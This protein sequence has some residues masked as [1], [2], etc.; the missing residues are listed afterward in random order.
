MKKLIS[1]KTELLF[2]ITFVVGL[3][4][5]ILTSF[6]IKTYKSNL[7]DNLKNKAKIFAKDLVASCSDSL[8]VNQYKTLHSLVER[9]IF[10]DD[11]I[12][13]EIYDKDSGEVIEAKITDA[14]IN[15]IIS[16]NKIDFNS[17][18][19][20]TAV[21]NKS[22]RNARVFEV[23][24]PIL[25]EGE[26]IFAI[27]ASND[28]I[29]SIKLKESI[30]AVRVTLSFANTD[31][32]IAK[33]LN[34]AVLISIVVVIFCLGLSLLLVRIILDPIE[35]L[36]ISVK[37][38]PNGK[39]SYKYPLLKIREIEYL[40]EA[41][42]SIEKHFDKNL[43]ALS[44]EKSEELIK[45]KNNLELV[46]KELLESERFLTIGSLAATLTHEIKNPLTSLQNIMFFFSQTKDFS[47]EK[48]AKMIEMFF[49]ELERINKILSELLSFSI[50]E[51][52]QKMDAYVDDIVHSAT[53]TVNLPK[54]IEIK[55]N[56]EHVKAEIDCSNLSKVLEQLIINARDS[57][58]DGGII[59]ISVKRCGDFVEIKVKDTG[60]GINDNILNNIWT[61]LFT[62]KLK[63]MGLGLA[64]VKKIVELHFGRITVTSE[65][66]KGT[67]F[68]I[69]IPLKEK[70][71]G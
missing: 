24:T 68:S 7:E 54:N 38:M 67:E 46:K 11:V 29:N 58:L 62:T 36:S 52:I 27:S 37:N 55:E 1:L 3:T 12:S 2:I 53:I 23:V 6:F 8:S 43:R 10:K 65:E 14:E 19:E 34:I 71:S 47:D 44:D 31:R 21:I 59:Y 41:F 4:S 26:D 13:A 15:K 40:V 56:F 66:N 22:K 69:N 45:M 9:A 50:L 20:T 57:M 51:N 64:I 18:G 42:N 33:T 32:K 30:G 35:K 39:F 16:D 70:T 28:E 60:S 25:K 48:S 63:S 5:I 17:I 49:A 61:P